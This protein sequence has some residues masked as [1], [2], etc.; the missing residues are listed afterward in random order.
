[1]A[2]LVVETGDKQRD[3][4]NPLF[5][6]AEA[7]V[8]AWLREQGHHVADTRKQ[9]TYYDCVV[10]HAYTLDCKVDSYAVETGRVAFETRVDTFDKRGVLT[11][12]HVGWGVNVALNYAAYVLVSDAK[13]WPLLVVDRACALQ[14]LNEELLRGN[15]VTPPFTK[16]DGEYREAHGHLLPIEWL[17]EQCCVVQEGEV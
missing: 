4:A 8:L 5:A 15:V 11:G 16:Q 7:R 14:R 10:D 17:R 9:K 1:M 2:R 6:S 12:G 3:V 13:A